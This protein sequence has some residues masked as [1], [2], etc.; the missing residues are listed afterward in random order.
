MPKRKRLTY[1][2]AEVKRLIKSALKEKQ[3]STCRRE[4]VDEAMK[5]M[6]TY[7]DETG[8]FAPGGL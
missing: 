8:K 7:T 5:A 6:R 4:A 1:R 2:R 3:D